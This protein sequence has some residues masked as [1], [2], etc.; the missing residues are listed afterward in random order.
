VSS[1]LR[2]AVERRSVGPLTWLSTRPRWVPFVIVLILLLGGL[3]L[4][5]AAAA[6]LLVVLGLLLVWLTYLAWP[7][8]EA[9]GRFSR[10][11]VLALVGYVLVQRLIG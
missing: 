4:P 5:V 10:L 11:L 7:K 1:P 9:T 8:L 3:F 6:V 2:R